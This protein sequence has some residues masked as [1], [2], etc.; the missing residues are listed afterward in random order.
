MTQVTLASIAYV[1]TQVTV[2]C[3]YQYS[4]LIASYF[5]G[6]SDLHCP[7]RLSFL[8]QTQLLTQR[9]SIP[10]SAIFSTTSKRDKKSMISLSG[11]TGT[12]LNFV[13]VRPLTA[14]FYLVR[15]FQAIRQLDALF[16]ATAS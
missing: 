8:G 3:L 7:P 6:R 10:Q 13:L 2:A 14:K 1:A 11:G 5:Y 9:D 4:S 12:A 16:V 15:F